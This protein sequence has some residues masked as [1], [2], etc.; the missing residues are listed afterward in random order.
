MDH[1][2]LNAMGD[3]LDC[4]TFKCPEKILEH[5]INI[6]TDKLIKPGKQAP[7]FLDFLIPL[8]K[9]GIHSNIIIATHIQGCE[10]TA[11]NKNSKLLWLTL[12]EKSLTYSSSYS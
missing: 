8:S 7:H 11:G 9:Y 1:N 6:V 4:I 2:D 10:A 12:L 5:I 3:L